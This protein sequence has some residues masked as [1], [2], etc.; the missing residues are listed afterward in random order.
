MAAEI[1]SGILD[2]TF[3]E[4]MIAFSVAALL[5][6]FSFIGRR[7][8]RSVITATTGDSVT[9]YV[10]REE[11]KHGLLPSWIAQGALSAGRMS[12]SIYNGAPD[13]LKLVSQKF[14]RPGET[15]QFS[16]RPGRY[17]LTSRWHRELKEN[18]EKSV[19]RYIDAGEYHVEIGLT[20]EPD[21]VHIIV[22]TERNRTHFAGE[23]EMR[24]ERVPEAIE[25]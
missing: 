14:L 23:E 10:K 18:I 5:I 19:S 9:L 3:E 24:A 17:T 12:F 2:I 8:Y 4:V 6:V 20:T 11:T 21:D 13:S 15:Y 16:T 22:R 25:S 7:I 1:E